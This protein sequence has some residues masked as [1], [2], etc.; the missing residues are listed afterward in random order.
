MTI[1]RRYAIGAVVIV[2]GREAIVR[3][4]VDEY[5][6]RDPV[7]RVELR[8]LGPAVADDPTRFVRVRESEITAP[9]G[10]WL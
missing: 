3:N 1:G 7:Y 2:A 5:G 8:P 4:H 6:T 9:K 10:G